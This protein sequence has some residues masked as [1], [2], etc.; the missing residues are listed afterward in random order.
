MNKSAGV[1]ALCFLLGIEPVTAFSQAA[2]EATIEP[3][4]K[5]Q[6]VL[7]THLNSK[8]NEPGDNIT[9]VLNEPIYVNGLLVME[10][11]TEFH[12]RVTAVTPAR[13]GQKQAQMT[14]VFD[15]VAM[16]WGEEPVAVMLTAIDDWNRDEKHKADSEGQVKGGHKGEKTAENVRRGGEIGGL[17]AG[18]VILGGAAAGAGPGI[19]GVGAAA[20][21][22][23]LLGGLLLTKGGEVRVDPGATFRI[24]FVKP[25]TLPIIQ[26]PGAAPRPIQQDEPGPKE[27]P[28]PPKKPDGA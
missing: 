5:A 13:R 1:L 4:T 19:L 2:K 22:G 27:G 18:A 6:I 3:D 20:I 26:Q 10:R 7:Q 16:P 9:A 25:L 12:G 11:G 28:P 21:G 14:I 24:K 17:G 15:R 23:G 8:L